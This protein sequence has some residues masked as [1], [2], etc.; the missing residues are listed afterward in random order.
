MFDFTKPFDINWELNNI[1]NLMCPQCGRNEIVDGVLQKRTDN[2]P[3]GETLDDRDNSLETFKKVF[4]G[5]INTCF[6]FSN[7]R[8]G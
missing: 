1:C 8:I 7:E 3:G 4:F 6:S 2:I 5:Y